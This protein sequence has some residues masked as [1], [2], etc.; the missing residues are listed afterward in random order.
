MTKRKGRKGGGKGSDFERLLCKSFSEWWTHGERDD[1]F[2]RTSQSGGR[3]TIRA[4]Y[5]RH[6]YGQFGDMS[7]T[8][9]IGEPLLRLFS[10]EFKRGYN[11]ETIFDL[12]DR[13]PN[14][15][16]DKPFP[17][18]QF[19][20]QSYKGHTNSGSLSWA[21]VHKR[22][23]RH[24]VIMFPGETLQDLVVDD[25]QGAPLHFSEGD[26]LKEIADHA[27]EWGMVHEPIPDWDAFLEVK[28]PF[29]GE[30]IYVT[31][32][33]QFFE[34]ISPEWVIEFVGIINKGEGE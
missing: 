13:T 19:M 25:G 20:D 14:H 28:P 8:D 30:I 16:Q 15:N 24:P 29:F 2:W 9:P 31:T 3:A 23:R 21:L 11:R 18:V 26:R 10:F 12:V 5:G 22:D 33:K 32:L 7:A 4:Q 6:T 34:I 27:Y 17:I 1:V